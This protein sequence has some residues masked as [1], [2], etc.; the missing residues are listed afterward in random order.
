MADVKL[1]EAFILTLA[2]R[3]SLVVKKAVIHAKEG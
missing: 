2:L 1:V 3:P